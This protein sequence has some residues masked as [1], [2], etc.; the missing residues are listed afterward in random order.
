MKARAAEKKNDKNTKADEKKGVNVTQ[1]NATKKNGKEKN[2]KQG[3]PKAKARASLKRPAAAM[4]SSGH[5][6]GQAS[7][8]G[9]PSQYILPD[10]Q[11]QDLEVARNVYVSR[12]YSKARVH[13]RIHLK[14]SEDDAK[15]Y[16]RK[17]L[18]QA[19]ATWDAAKKKLGDQ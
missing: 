16:G 13:A 7:G 18:K 15:E 1:K 17:F 2:G 4:G 10:L 6:H 3:K 12:H 9:G 11:A 19:G 14:M 8:T 5:G